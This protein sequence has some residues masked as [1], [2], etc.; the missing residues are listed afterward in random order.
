MPHEALRTLL[1][2]AGWSE[3]EAGAVAFSGGSDPVLPTPFR[4]GT[5]AAATLA[6]SG[7]AAARLWEART[8]RRQRVGVNLR[9]AAASLRSGHYMRLGDGKVSTARNTIMG[10]YPSRDGRWSYLHCNF[11]N[12]R[13][14]ALKVLGVAEDRDAVARAVATWNAADLEE[15]IIAA[16]GAGGMARTRAE[17]AEHPQAAAIAALPLLEIVRIGDS[18]PEPLPSG[19]R[20]LAGIRVLDLTRVLAGPTCARTLAEHGAEV[21]KITAAHLP[22]LG[23][24]EWDTGHGK[25][26]AQLDLRDAAQVDILRGLVGEA[27]VF[28]QGYRPGTLAGRGLA[29]EELARIRPGLVYV[30]LCAFGHQGPW[31][32]RRGFDTVVQTVSGITIRQAE[33]VPGARPGPSF[34][35]V[36]AIDYCTGYLMAFGAMVALLRRTQEGGSWLVRISLAQVGKWILDLGEVP[37]AALKGV[38]AEFTPSELDRWS[39]VSQTP[40]GPLRHLKP[41]VALEET[42]PYWARPSVPLGYHP[43]VWP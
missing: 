31:A 37:E 10:V 23:Y 14:A 30:S 25:L 38:P 8:G 20:P 35:P 4:I 40:S 43:P 32:S 2:I 13:A 26:S 11:P 7:L 16:G 3:H 22:N 18:A 29:P 42:P 9:H 21:M 12:H 33:C 17:W 36:S 6:A 28:S 34:Y 27:H 24:Q 39:T 15:A 41:V 19:D 5:A 1:P